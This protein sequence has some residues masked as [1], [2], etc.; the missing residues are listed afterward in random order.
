MGLYLSRQIIGL[1]T[2]RNEFFYNIFP[3]VLSDN[4]SISTYNNVYKKFTDDGDYPKELRQICID[5]DL[6]YEKF[7]CEKYGILVEKGLV[8]MGLFKGGFYNYKKTDNLPILFE[9]YL[10]QVRENEPWAPYIYSF[11]F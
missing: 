7:F 11:F 3:L 10:K 6:F 5:F 4:L 1:Q 9:E 2:S 8:S